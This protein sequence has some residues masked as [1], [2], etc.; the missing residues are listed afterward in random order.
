LLSGVVI[1]FPGTDFSI[2]RCELTDLPAVLAIERA[3][4]PRP[5]SK[6]QFVQELQADYSRLDLLLFRNDLAGYICYWLTAG[7]MHILNVAT[8]L[9]FRR[10]GVARRL[11][12]HVF[13]QAKAAN[14]EL[15]CLEVRAGNSGAIALY[16]DFG[17]S[18]D[19][20]RPAYYSDGEDALLMSCALKESP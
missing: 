20:I 16:R 18:D 15:A 11:L 14:A 3:S 12:E 6:L 10:K 19:C 7:E 1:A 8:A 17:F 13:C 5:W 2:R 9:T 4:Y